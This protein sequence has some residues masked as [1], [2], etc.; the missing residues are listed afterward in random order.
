MSQ[1][2][3]LKGLI[4]VAI[5]LSVVMLIA[6]LAGFFMVKPEKLDASVDAEITANRIKPIGTVITSDMPQPEPAAAASAEPQ[7]PEQIYNTVCTA[8]HATGVLESPKLDD[9]AAWTARAAK[10][11]DGLLSSAINGLNNMPPRGGNPSLSDDELKATIEY[12]L[13]Q[14]GVAAE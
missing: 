3:N 14:A 11:I 12:M 2:K 1:T 13:G 7:S 9:N 5:I 4:W 6:F 8:C 10:G